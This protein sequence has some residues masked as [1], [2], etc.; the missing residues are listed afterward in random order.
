M[1][2]AQRRAAYSYPRNPELEAAAIAEEE[3][4]IAEHAA[5]PDEAASDE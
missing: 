4:M 1:T 3:K 2:P 5:H